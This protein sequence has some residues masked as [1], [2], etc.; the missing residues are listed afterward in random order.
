MIA[1]IKLYNKV[2]ISEMDSVARYIL[3]EITNIVSELMLSWEP[4]DDNTTICD[5]GNILVLC[6]YTYMYNIFFRWYYH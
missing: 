6:L 2:L 5:S 3:A 1:V 4:C